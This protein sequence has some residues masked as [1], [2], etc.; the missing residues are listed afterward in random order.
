VRFPAIGRRVD[1]HTGVEQSPQGWQAAVH[2]RHDQ[3]YLAGIRCLRDGKRKAARPIIGAA[4]DPIYTAARGK[5]VLDHLRTSEAGGV[6]QVLDVRPAHGQPLGCVRV[7]EKQR[8]PQ[9]RA[10]T[11]D[12]DYGGAM[13]DQHVYQGCL[14]A[15]QVR[16]DAGHQQA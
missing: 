8:A 5:H 14:H 15:R 10:V 6:D 2:G 12:A 1:V 11:R 3:G 13:I 16:V 9:R 4:Q 7:S